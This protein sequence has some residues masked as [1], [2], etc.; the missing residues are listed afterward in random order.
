MKKGGKKVNQPLSTKE[1]NI[2]VLV[3]E[4]YGKGKGEFEIETILPRYYPKVKLPSVWFD[5]TKKLQKHLEKNIKEDKLKEV[6]DQCQMESPAFSNVKTEL[7]KATPVV[8]VKKSKKH[9]GTYFA[10]EYNEY[11]SGSVQR[12]EYSNGYIQDV[13]RAEEKG[14]NVGDGVWDEDLRNGSKYESGTGD[15]FEADKKL[16]W[17]K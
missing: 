7:I 13:I 12:E 9:Y 4:K 16:P 11:I 15:W 3:N 5:D 6:Y 1:K 2:Y 10:H 14:Y 17:V 8:I